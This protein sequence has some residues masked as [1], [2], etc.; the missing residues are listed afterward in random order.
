LAVLCAWTCS[1]ECIEV[2][3]ETP[4]GELRVSAF[5]GTGA[6]IAN[7]VVEILDRGAVAHSTR[8]GRFR[9]LP[10]GSYTVRVYAPGFRSTTRDVEVVQPEAHLRV[11]LGLGGG[12]C[13]RF[14]S[15]LAGSVTP[16]AGRELWLKLMPLR[17][18]GGFETQVGKAGAFFI[19]GLDGGQYVVMVVAGESVL[20][21]QVLSI[22]GSA[23]L[24]IDLP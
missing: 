22:A 14:T 3:G 15:S 16:T 18:T 24:K 20:H 21:S 1:A 12:D 6:V 17:G 8:G 5:D 11:Q 13:S 9:S 4:K 2:K 19:G 23:K 10:Y 7:P